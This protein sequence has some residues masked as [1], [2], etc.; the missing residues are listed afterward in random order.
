MTNR[1]FSLLYLLPFIDPESRLPH[2]VSFD[3]IQEVASFLMGRTVLDSEIPRILQALRLKVRPIW[4]K[5]LEPEVHT[6]L[7]VLSPESYE[8]ACKLIAEHHNYLFDIH[9]LTVAQVAVIDSHV[10]VAPTARKR[11]SGLVKRFL[12]WIGLID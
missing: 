5:L 6:I 1:R 7:N 11:V 12:A 3:D 2:G 10:Y 8:E 4:L 9:P